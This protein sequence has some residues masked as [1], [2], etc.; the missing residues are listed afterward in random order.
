MKKI[1][2][3]G[4]KKLIL[5]TI[6]EELYEAK[7]TTEE[8]ADPLADE[9]PDEQEKL[10][11]NSAKAGAEIATATGQTN[12]VPDVNVQKILDSYEAA[13]SYIK[14]GLSDSSE[15]GIKQARSAIETVLSMFPKEEKK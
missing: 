1:N 9:N 7:K 5:E 12:N 11:A 10:A 6:E 13:K 15:L 4:L 8:A 14:T 2:K 3:D